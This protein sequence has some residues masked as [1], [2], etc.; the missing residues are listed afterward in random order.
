MNYIR[1]FS[2]YMLFMTM[3]CFSASIDRVYSTWRSQGYWKYA[4]IGAGLFLSSFLMKKNVYARLS[5]QVAGGATLLGS[6]YRA[7]K[8]CTNSPMAVDDVIKKFLGQGHT[9]CETEQE[10]IITPPESSYRLKNLSV[11]GNQLYI[12]GV[13][14]RGGCSH[15]LSVACSQGNNRLRLGK[16]GPGGTSTIQDIKVGTNTSLRRVR[17]KAYAT[18]AGSSGVFSCVVL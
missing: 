6:V 9:I 3:T 13:P 18:Q 11:I 15:D 16:G 8:V 12:G 2:L 1:G 17:R 7:Y 14:W 4:S 10:Y 5:L